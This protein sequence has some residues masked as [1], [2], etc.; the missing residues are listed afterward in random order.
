[1]KKVLAVTVSVLSLTVVA[2]P[3]FCET[4][5]GKVDGKAKFEQ[6]C[7]ACHPEGGNIIKPDKSIGKKALAGRGIRKE[8]DVVAK[9]RNPGPGMTKFDAK[10]LPDNEAEAVAKYILTTFR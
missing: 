1:M 9:I 4:K 7:A 3:G 6:L 5:A 8:K 10:A 2:A